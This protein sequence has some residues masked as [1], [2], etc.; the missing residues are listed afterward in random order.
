MQPLSPRGRRKAKGA[1]PGRPRAVHEYQSA[2]VKSMAT[3]RCASPSTPSRPFTPGVVVA[4]FAKTHH[5]QW[6]A[7]RQLRPPAGRAPFFMHR[8][9]ICPVH[10]AAFFHTT[11]HLVSLNDVV[12]GF[13]RRYGAVRLAGG[14]GCTP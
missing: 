7:E 10:P 8:P 4:S 1:R 11:R 9:L 14:K 13:T 5:Q 6:Q 3:T 12:R 2:K